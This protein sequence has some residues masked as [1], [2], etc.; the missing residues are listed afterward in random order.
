LAQMNPEQSDQE[1]FGST[2]CS[3]AERAEFYFDPLCQLAP[4]RQWLGLF[5]S[6]AAMNK[7]LALINKSSDVGIAT[8]KRT[9]ACAGMVGPH[10]RPSNGQARLSA[11]K[12]TEAKMK[13][14]LKPLAI[15]ALSVTAVAFLSSARAAEKK[16]KVPEQVCQTQALASIAKEWPNVLRGNFEIILKGNRCLVFLQASA[17]F[18]GKRTAWLIDGKNGELLSEFYGPK[19]S[20]RGLCSYRS[21]KF[22]TAQCTWDEYL[23]KA[24]QM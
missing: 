2:R 1:T 3:R 11:L 5:P 10:S 15:A 4:A 7:C 9:G 12:S 20:D 13:T 8:N 16:A 23:D 18:E 21:G 14:L 19:N 17:I 24:N 6:M 22:P